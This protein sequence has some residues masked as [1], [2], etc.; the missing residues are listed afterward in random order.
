MS[1]ESSN[2]IRKQSLALQERISGLIKEIDEKNAECQA[3]ATKTASAENKLF[4]AER[5]VEAL[6]TLQSHR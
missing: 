1:Q 3:L 2:E 5:R 4:E 6:A